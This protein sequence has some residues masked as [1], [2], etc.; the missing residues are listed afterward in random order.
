LDNTHRLHGF[1]RFNKYFTTSAKVGAD[2]QNSV[3]INNP[4]SY[5][6]CNENQMKAADF[7]FSPLILEQVNSKEM[8]L[9]QGQFNCMTATEYLFIA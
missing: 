7:Y 8:I 9:I 4:S 3:R 2:A 6:I 1:K 5:I